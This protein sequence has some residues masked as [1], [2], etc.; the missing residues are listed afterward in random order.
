MILYLLLCACESLSATPSKEY[1]LRL[2]NKMLRRIR[3]RKEQK[4]GENYI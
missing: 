2:E 3:E 4:Y 1:R